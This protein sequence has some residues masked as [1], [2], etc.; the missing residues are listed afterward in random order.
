M[1]ICK[2]RCEHCHAEH[3]ATEITIELRKIANVS[4]PQMECG[5]DMP[6]ADPPLAWYT[7]DFCNLK[8]LLNWLKD[9]ETT[10]HPSFNG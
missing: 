5:A 4:I 8:C 2:T 9:L 6:S 10:K 1:K 3:D 7:Y